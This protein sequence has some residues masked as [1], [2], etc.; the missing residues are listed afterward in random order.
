MGVQIE[1]KWDRKTK[2]FVDIG[3]L[4]D[5][6]RV[7]PVVRVLIDVGKLQVEAALTSGRTP[8]KPVVPTSQWR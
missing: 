6:K 5:L 3:E 1:L 2:D 7:V 8:G 4:D